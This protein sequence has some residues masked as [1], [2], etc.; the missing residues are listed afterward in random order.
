MGNYNED[1]FLSE[2]FILKN[3]DSR[4]TLYIAPGLLRKKKSFNRKDGAMEAYTEE[5]EK[6]I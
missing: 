3:D 1:V 2:P 6:N 5:I 4:S